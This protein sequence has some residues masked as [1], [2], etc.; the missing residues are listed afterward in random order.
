MPQN[1]YP[2]PPTPPTS[3]PR[4]AAKRKVWT[5]QVAE[6]EETPQLHPAYVALGA[7]WRR[8]LL[9]ENM[10]QGTL[11]IYLEAHRRL[12][13]F[14]AREG[15]AALAPEEIARDHIE[16]WVI[17][18]LADGYA[19]AS[20]SVFYR[21][22]KRWFTWLEEE[23]EIPQSP[24]R[25]MK[26]PKVPETIKPVLSDAQVLAILDAC[27]GSAFVD[28]RDLALISLL[29]DTGMRRSEAASIQIERLSLDEQFVTVASAKG[30]RDRIIAFGRQTTRVLDRYL[31]RR[32][33]HPFAAEPWLFLGRAGRTTPSGVYQIVVERAI[34]A[35]IEERVYPHLFRHTYAHLFLEA[36]GQESDLMAQAGWRSPQMVRHYG[37][38]LREKRARDSARRLSPADR[39]QEKRATE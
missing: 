21:A 22:I 35:G 31:R 7:S 38:A 27:R 30:R 20:A 26:P 37:A 36:G 2:Q 13:F 11:T 18:L 19:A 29:F 39:M 8:A 28:L 23:Q 9:A 16:R 3:D 5:P 10:A 15:L 25:R 6:G 1:D 12:G 14:L 24:M 34:A 4:R 32:A 17:A 33:R